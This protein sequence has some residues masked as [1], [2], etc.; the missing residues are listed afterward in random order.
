MKINSNSTAILTG[1]YLGRS[2]R[3]L[4]A[5]AK[6]LSSGY[7]I[8]N[9]SDN[10]SGYALS[11]KM[12]EQIRSLEKACDNTE[13]GVDFVRTADG[14]LNEVHD[15]LQRAN[16]LAIKAANG[17][18]TPADRDAI[19]LEMDQL[20]N[21]I[22]RISEQTDFNG[23]PILNGNYEYRG[24]VKSGDER[25]SVL[26]YNEIVPEGTYTLSFSIEAKEVLDA[27]GKL[28]GYEYTADASSVKQLNVSDKDPLIAESLK[29][30]VHGSI[31]RIKGGNGAQLDI[32]LEDGVSGTC[33]V[34]VELNRVGAMRIQVGDYE[35]EVI[36]MSIPQINLKKLSMEDIDM[37]TEENAKKG[38]E[39][40]RYAIEY[41]S[42]VRSKLG[43]YQNRLEHASASL[44][45]SVESLNSSYSTITDTDMAEEMTEYT[46][47]QVL[48]QAATS[49]LAQANEFP[50]QALQLLQ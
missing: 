43:A 12:R 14:A 40:I 4:A 26:G 18:M 29:A 48:Q 16:E 1:N 25:L 44:D 6:K 20:C 5:S 17:T 42:T 30:E 21:E 33:Q 31:L 23:S 49:M 10:P 35:G 50:Q 38:I 9:A 11:S 7:K 2:E 45:I 3:S 34:E 28:A 24:Y 19:E 37:S 39:K 27:Q 32:G 47:F 22:T 41:T 15:M 46:K 13:M 36:E 8:N